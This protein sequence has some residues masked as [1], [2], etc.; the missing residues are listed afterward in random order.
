MGR[1]RGRRALTRPAVARRHATACR[2][3]PPRKAAAPEPWCS[4][5]SALVF[6]YR[7][8]FSADA[9][10]AA[11]VGRGGRGGRRAIETATVNLNCRGIFR[12]WSLEPG[13]RGAPS[14]RCSRGLGPRKQ[15]R[16]SG[17]RLRLR[18]GLWVRR[19]LGPC[20]WSEERGAREARPAVGGWKKRRR[21][22]L[23]PRCAQSTVETRA[24]LSAP[25]HSA[26]GGYAC[27]WCACN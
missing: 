3:A 9:H 11:A 17:V 13:A 6:V 15:T 4:P 16:V 2:G 26:Y 22:R 5:R 20:S 19:A 1:S 23:R 21:H 24:R 14:Q 12:E 8:S 10:G 27:G 18:V 25:A 7:L